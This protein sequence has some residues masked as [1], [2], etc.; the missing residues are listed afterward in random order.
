M[1]KLKNETLQKFLERLI[2]TLEF[3][4]EFRHKNMEKDNLDIPFIIS[5][6]YQSFK[7]NPSDYT[8]FI[9]DLEKYSDYGFSIENSRNDYNGIID[10]Y[11]YLSKEMNCWDE[12]TPNYD[13][14]I[15]FTYDFRD[16]GYCMC[17][18]GM[19]D[20]REDKH[21][22]GHGCDT[23]FCEFSLQKIFYIKRDS[24]HGDEHSYWDF[25]DEFYLNDGEFVVKKREEDKEVEIRELKKRID[26]DSKRLAELE[27]E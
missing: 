4:K 9:S 7:N 3:E 20:Y 18:P 11:I 23:T 6:L 27:G 10:V 25:E 22:C 21:C 1:K 5:S 8:E 15:S 13:Y 2:E 16:Y 19:D 17:T 14:L 24:W 26:E 12:E